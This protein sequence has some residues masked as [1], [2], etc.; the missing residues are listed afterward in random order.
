MIKDK[1]VVFSGLCVDERN[2]ILKEAHDIITGCRDADYPDPVANFNTISIFAKLL[3]G[4]DLTASDCC[5]VMIAVKLARD[6][7]KGKRDNKV[8]I[9][10]YY[11]IL[12]MIEIENSKKV[13]G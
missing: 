4:K 9:A 3:T 8:D 6:S 10:A 1:D 13:C 11:E 7:Y 2:S 5:K 12:D